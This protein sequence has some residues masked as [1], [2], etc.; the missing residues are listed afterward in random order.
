VTPSRDG[1]SLSE[2]DLGRERGEGAGDGDGGG[3]GGR[4]PCG[5]WRV[6]EPP[7][8]RAAVVAAPRV[9]VSDYGLLGR[10]GGSDDDLHRLCRL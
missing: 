5:R 7:S 6:V 1:F 2:S 9:E 3:G 8:R 4:G 10:R